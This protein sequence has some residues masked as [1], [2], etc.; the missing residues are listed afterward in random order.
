MKQSVL[1]ASSVLMVIVVLSGAYVFRMRSIDMIG[2][3]P[4]ENGKLRVVATFYPLGE[5]SR[6]V[7]GDR[8]DVSVIVPAGSEPHEYEPTPQDI[9]S[10]YSADVVVVNGAGV[11]AWAV[12]IRSDLENKGVKVVVMS[13]MLGFIEGGDAASNHEEDDHD[14]EEGYGHN[15]GLDPH[16]WL[17]PVLAQQ[18]VSVIENALKSV[19]MKNQDVYTENARAYMQSLRVLDESYRESLFS[20]G[21]RT[22]VTS[23]D[24]FGYLARRYGFD[25][26]SI[27]G[28]SP[29]SEPST[30][31]LADLV[32]LARQKNI[33]FI[34]FETL[35]SP[36][37]SQTLANEIGAETLVFNPLEGLTED[38]IDLGKNYIS[39]MRENLNNLR[40]A[41]E[42]Y[43]K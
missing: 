36:R 1:I 7:G 40:I 31:Q 32:V 4:A 8:T 20:C 9:A 19:D 16:F 21:E 17:D 2:S 5:F 22:V 12:K 37:L 11:D 26:L 42:C 15:G 25:S 24:A 18:E 35:V 30:R 41:M 10:M 14:T 3:V 33:R 6:Q 39:V 13:D 27:A 29:E 23:H 38:E 34:F 43:G 28:F